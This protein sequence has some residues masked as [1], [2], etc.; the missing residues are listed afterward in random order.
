MQDMRQRMMAQGRAM[1]MAPMP[2]AAGPQTRPMGPGP[3]QGGAVPGGMGGPMAGGTAGIDGADVS[4]PEQADRLVQSLT[5][6]LESA[7]A[8]ASSGRALYA[9][10]TDEQKKTAD[11]LLAMPMRGM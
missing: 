3:I 2:P 8:I 4:F 1:P 6:R 5:A 9:V 10:L 11:E 7:R